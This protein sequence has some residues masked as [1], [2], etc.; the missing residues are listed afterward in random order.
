MIDRTLSLT[1]SDARAHYDKVRALVDETYGEDARRAVEV[2]FNIGVSIAVSE[3]RTTE[4]VAEQLGVTARLIRK[5]ARQKGIGKDI[6]RDWLFSPED[7][8]T[9]KGRKTVPGPARKET[10]VSGAEQ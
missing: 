10:T 7:I 8:D 1:A 2:A 3:L 6:G 4:E 9:L 5:Y